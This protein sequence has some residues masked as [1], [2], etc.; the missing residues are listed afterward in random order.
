MHQDELSSRKDSSSKRFESSPDCV[1]DDWEDDET[2]SYG[3]K[4]D[5]INSSDE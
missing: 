1:N 2:D 4:L 5:S 3:D